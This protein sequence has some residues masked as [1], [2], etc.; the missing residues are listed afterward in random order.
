MDLQEKIFLLEKIIIL[1]LCVF[2]A[3]LIGILSL[4]AGGLLLDHF[5]DLMNMLTAPFLIN[6]F[7]DLF[8]TALFAMFLIYLVKKMTL[9]VVMYFVWGIVETII[10][11]IQ[12]SYAKF[13]EVEPFINLEHFLPKSSL[14]ISL[15]TSGIVEPL[16][17][18]VT[19]IYVVLMLILPYFLFTKADIKS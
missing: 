12:T 11:S 16:A 5:D 2:L 3:F 17:V 15:S 10:V 7:I 6:F 13:N 9:A 4:F 19:A 14:N 8:Y 1:F 18:V